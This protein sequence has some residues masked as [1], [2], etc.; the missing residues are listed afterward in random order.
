[1]WLF[2]FNL[3]MN[4]PNINSNFEFEFEKERER[5]KKN[6][7]E[8]G[9]EK[10]KIK[11]RENLIWAKTHLSRPTKPRMRQSTTALIHWS[12]GPLSRPASTSCVCFTGAWAP[13]IKFIPFPCPVRC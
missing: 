13:P 7:N 1:M 10:G 9:I 4:S 3:S 5:E 11:I 6:R 2:K 8:K 12:M